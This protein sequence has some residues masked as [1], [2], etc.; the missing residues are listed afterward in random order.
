M[1]VLGLS[2]G[3]S[4]EDVE[5]TPDIQD[6][7]FH[8]AA[9]CLLRDGHVL[10][11]VE[12]ERLNRIKQ[13][14]KF[15]ARAVRACLAEAGVTLADVD[16]IS[17]YFREDFL[18]AQ[19]HMQYMNNP[20]IPVVYSRELVRR[21]L[22]EEL[23]TDFPADRISYT[24]HH[25]AHATATFAHSGMSEAL[26]VV[27]DARGDDESWTFYRGTESGL[28]QLTTHS[29]MHSLGRLYLI[30]TA[31][32]GYK[33]GDEYKV[34]GLAPYGD[35]ERYRPA[36]DGCYT[37]RDKGAFDLDLGALLPA[38]AMNGF[39]WRRR[40]EGFGQDHKDFAA[41]LQET[42]E[43][44]TLHALTH[45]REATGLG[46]LCLSGGVA[47]NCT[48]NGKVLRS[49]LFDRVFVH[50]ASHDAGAAL[51]AALAAD[52]Q[53]D[54]APKQ[55]HAANWGPGI[56]N[57]DQIRTELLAW[58]PLV[59]FEECDDI[60]ARTADLLADGSVVAWV[61]GR[62]EFGPRA[63]GNRSILAD[64]RPKENQTRINAMIKMRESFRPFAPVVTT[65]AA[66]KY[67]EIPSAEGNFDFMSFVL[68]VREEHRAALGAVTHVDGTARV[69][70]VD[71]AA[72]PRF[73]ELVT[74]FGDRTGVPVLLNTSFNNHAEP[75]VQN[76]RDA[77]ATYLT[78]GLDRLV[79]G[80]FL[81]RRK[82]KP[83]RPALETCTVVLPAAVRLAESVQHDGSRRV[84]THELFFALAKGKRRTVSPEAY[85][86]L[87]RT[88]SQ[89][90][91]GTLTDELR[92]ELH[93]L[94][95][96]RFIAIVPC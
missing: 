8:D 36:F 71:P 26:V 22:A 73:S 94:W 23:G 20:D 18:D 24:P 7:F 15:P 17:Y 93:Q 63:L 52:D 51:G 75:I 74:R 58:E 48:M 9:A 82:D 46:D 42:V 29:V 95:Q 44:I 2:G 83:G 35:P 68:P 14:T 65:E 67:F 1:L 25:L 4:R 30:G 5:L 57:R 86:V 76:V 87:S 6:N 77:L 33:M 38:F 49:G 32:L 56:G 80:D 70:V 12:Q 10:A 90:P 54:R 89:T 39:T 16:R 85:A 40:G 62:S 47:H 72:N 84:V 66:E 81:V 45:W 13:T 41:A 53:R 60:V 59:E 34:M 79:I 64:P 21:R 43:R 61:Q 69:Q 28:E 37:L 92:T 55:L 11:A 19:L 27:I 3:F 31:M 50:P 88:D 78:T 96:D 91:I